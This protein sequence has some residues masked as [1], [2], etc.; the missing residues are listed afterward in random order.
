MKI[1]PQTALQTELP[2][3]IRII[4]GFVKGDLPQVFFFADKENSGKTIR[5]F[6]LFPIQKY[7]SDIDKKFQ[8][9][10]AEKYRNSQYDKAKLRILESLGPASFRPKTAQR[11]ALISLF[12]A[13][14]RTDTFLLSI[15]FS[16]FFRFPGTFISGQPLFSDA[17]FRFCLFV[18]RSFYPVM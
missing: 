14:V 6:L 7:R 18:L 2:C 1:S 8:N 16:Q 10:Y 15:R 9:K 12:S 13:F 5:A 4:T 11:T 17:V 3:F